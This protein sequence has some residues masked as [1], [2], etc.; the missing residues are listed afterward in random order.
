M[1]FKEKNPPV[2]LATMVAHTN[3]A[4]EEP[5]WLADSGANA[6]IT[7]ALENLHIQQPFQHND[8]VA[9]G[10]GTGKHGSSL[11]TLTLLLFNLIIFYIVPK[12]L[13][14]YFQF[15]NSA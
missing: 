7:N 10:K 14:I 1:H 12:P 3:A 4:Y 13:P 9:V 8:E 11:S 6:H 5:Q 2:Q 15:K